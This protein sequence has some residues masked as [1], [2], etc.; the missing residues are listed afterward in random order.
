MNLY[1]EV[2]VL[3]WNPP[4]MDTEQKGGY[5]CRA[6]LIHDVDGGKLLLNDSERFRDRDD[7]EAQAAR[8]RENLTVAG[9][10]VR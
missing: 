5:K 4:H 9:I 2:E 6:C 8:F 1:A 7:A 3:P 10:E